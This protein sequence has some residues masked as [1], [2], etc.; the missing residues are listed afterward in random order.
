MSLQKVSGLLNVPYVLQDL[1]QDLD[2]LSRSCHGIRFA[3]VRSYQESHV[4]KENFFV[5]Y[6]FVTSTSHHQKFDQGPKIVRIKMA[7]LAGR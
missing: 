4:T 6:Y 5:K 7:D 2:K 3:M 1:S